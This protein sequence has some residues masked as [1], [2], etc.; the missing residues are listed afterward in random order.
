[1]NKIW[2][3]HLREAFPADKM[4][5]KDT[6]KNKTETPPEAKQVEIPIYG[7]DEKLCP[8]GMYLALFHGRDTA[9]KQMDDWG[10]NGPL[11]GPLGYVHTTYDSEIKIRFLNEHGYRSEEVYGQ[12]TGGNEEVV[13]RTHGELFPFAGKFYGDW[14]VFTI[15]NGRAKQ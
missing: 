14:T 1:M 5:E 3:H 11:I 2:A 8:D 7:K 10:F 6:M 12:E 13:F 4:I 15:D 9:D